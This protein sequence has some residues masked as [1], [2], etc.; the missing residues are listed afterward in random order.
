MK[1]YWTGEKPLWQ[2][3]WFLFVG[4]Y[5]AILIANFTI[6]GMLENIVGLRLIAII[7]LFVT[8]SY[9][10]VSLVSVWKC[11]KNTKWKGW[12]WIARTVVFAAIFKATYSAYFL[13]SNIIPKIENIPKNF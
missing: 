13:F 2:S 3:F 1:R 12:G 4:G 11:S 8:L 5:I 6:F 9:L 10:T 7:L